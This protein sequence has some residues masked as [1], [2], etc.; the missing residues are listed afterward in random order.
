MRYAVS[1]IGSNTV[2]MTV[3]DPED[4]LLMPLLSQ[5]RPVGLAGYRVAEDGRESLSPEGISALCEVLS[6]YRSLSEKI[7]CAVF[8]ALATASLRDLFNADEVIR[9]VRKTCGVEIEIIGGEREAEL[10]FIGFCDAA[11]GRFKWGPEDGLFV[12]MG[13]GSAEFVAIRGGC[14]VS[15]TSLPLGALKLYH[16]FVSGLLPTAEEREALASHVENLLSEGLPIPP[17]GGET[18]Y[19]TGGTAKAIG[20]VLARRFSLPA[21]NMAEYSPAHFLTL[22]SELAAGSPSLFHRLGAWVPDRL[23]MLIPGLTVICRLLSRVGTT[24]VFTVYSG[25]RD[26]FMI[27]RLRKEL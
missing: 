15:R 12:D 6:D 8:R 10:G 13:G 19:L 5:S 17:F 2:K 14:S 22:S 7:G 25:I 9:T 20:K 16:T 23:P 11:A 21:G 18:L 24:R 1:D 3:Y 26:G 27:D 4:G